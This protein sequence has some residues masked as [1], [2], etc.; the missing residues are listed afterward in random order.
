MVN[1]KTS[2]KK[3]REDRNLPL[4]DKKFQNNLFFTDKPDKAKL[5]LLRVF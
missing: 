2:H 1:Q 3:I 4:Y 5:I